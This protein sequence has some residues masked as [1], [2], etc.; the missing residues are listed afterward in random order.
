[1]V[2]VQTLYS[3]IKQLRFEFKSLVFDTPAYCFKESVR[4]PAN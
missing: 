2:L 3:Q 1:M 4:V